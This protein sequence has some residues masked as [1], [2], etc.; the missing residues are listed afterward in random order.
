V[1][2]IGLS[3]QGK[4]MPMNSKAS[5]LVVDD[6]AFVRNLACLMPSKLGCAPTI[7]RDGLEALKLIQTVDGFHLVLTDINMP[8]IDGWELALRVKALKPA[9][10]IVALTGESPNGILPRLQGSGISHA[11]F[12]PI[13]M[14]LLGDALS[15]I[16]NRDSERTPRRLQLG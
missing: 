8:E 4:T 3:A 9:L 1:F 2:F 7:A 10:P 12:K 16:L 5:I 11:L 6:E 13:R 15:G 14:D